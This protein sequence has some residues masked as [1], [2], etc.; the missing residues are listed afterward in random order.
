MRAG[1]VGAVEV[2]DGRRSPAAK[3]PVIAHI[4]PEPTC[5]GPAEP[6]EEYRNRRVVAMDLLGGKD[7]RADGGDDRVEQ[8]SGLT[9]PVAQGGTIEL[10][11]L[12]G[13][14]LA[15]PIEASANERALWYA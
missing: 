7:M 14:N 4:S 9:D 3:G 13:V 12:P 10:Q 1:A 6:G 5:L 15:L 8:P 2:G 11:T